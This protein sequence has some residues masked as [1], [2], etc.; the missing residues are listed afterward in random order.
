MD[1]VTTVV[2]FDPGETTGLVVARWVKGKTFFLEKVD[3]I[4]W[5]ERFRAV[6]K[7]LKYY[8]PEHIV[9]EEFRLYPHRARTQIGKTFPSSQFIGIIEAYAYENGYLDRVHMQPASVRKSVRIDP[10]HRKMVGSSAH[11]QDAYMHARYFIIV[12]LLKGKGT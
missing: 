10:E 4:F 1:G 6:K 9:V 2:S 11:M 7:N 5:G 8:Q 3:E 12:N